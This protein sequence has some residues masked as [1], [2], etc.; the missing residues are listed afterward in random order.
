MLL[1]C[2]NHFGQVVT[3]LLLE[4]EGVLFYRPMSLQTI[5]AFPLPTCH[6]RE[7][8]FVLLQASWS[9]SWA[10]LSHPETWPVHIQMKQG[11]AGGPGTHLSQSAPTGAGVSIQDTVWGSPASALRLCGC[12]SK[13]GFMG[14]A[15]NKSCGTESLTGHQPQ[16]A[17]GYLQVPHMY[18][19]P[20][21]VGAQVG[22]SS[23]R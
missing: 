22:I 13:E 17:C 19:G 4:K 7:R 16:N 3:G 20:Q 1:I 6:V 2:D 14:A 12:W 15:R 5:W 11:I 9:S 21:E 10:S 23:Y 8:L 18:L